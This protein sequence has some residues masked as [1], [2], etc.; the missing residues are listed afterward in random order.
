MEKEILDK[1][2]NLNE[3]EMLTIE[4]L[5]QVA[6]GDAFSSL[7][8]GDLDANN[9]EQMAKLVFELRQCGRDKGQVRTVIMYYFN[10]DRGRANILVNRYWG[11]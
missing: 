5:E 11:D 8:R 3:E 1:K 6:G 9:P 7:R 2:A 4:E 10:L